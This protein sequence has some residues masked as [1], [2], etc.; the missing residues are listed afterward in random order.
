MNVCLRYR[1]GPRGMY[2]LLTKFTVLVLCVH[3]INSNVGFQMQ[4]QVL[5][6]RIKPRPYLVKFDL[7]SIFSV[8]ISSLNHGMSNLV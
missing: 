6:H 4:W 3:T 5:S 7:P 1:T 2:S 8:T